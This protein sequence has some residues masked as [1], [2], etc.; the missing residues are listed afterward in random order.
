MVLGTFGIIGTGSG[1]ARGHIVAPWRPTF[2][3]TVHPVRFLDGQWF[4]VTL[5]S[6]QPH[7][8]NIIFFVSTNPRAELACGEL[9]EPVEASPAC[10]R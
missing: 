8:N 3:Q 4:L 1:D 6:D 7:L 2:R 10:S 9:V 5:K